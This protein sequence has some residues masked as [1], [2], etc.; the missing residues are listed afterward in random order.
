VDVN[1]QQYDSAERCNTE[2]AEIATAVTET[3]E[4]Q[5]NANV[6]MPLGV[7]VLTRES[8]NA[9]R[10]YPQFAIRNDGMIGGTFDNESAGVTH[11]VKG[12]VDKKTQRATWKAADDTNPDLIL[13][14]EIYN[15]SKDQR[16]VL[17][18]FGPE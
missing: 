16:D 1:G 10:M 9:T 13:E 14:A 12:M 8:V 17:V 15:V 5:A 11:L 2:A 18:Q 6:W 7:F 4:K 3:N